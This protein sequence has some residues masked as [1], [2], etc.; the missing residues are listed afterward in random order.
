MTGIHKLLG[1]VIITSVLA[2]ASG[3]AFLSHAS[4]LSNCRMRGGARMYSQPRCLGETRLCLSFPTHKTQLN[5]LW[6]CLAEHRCSGNVCSFHEVKDTSLVVQRAALLPLQKL[7]VC[8][9]L[10]SQCLKKDHRA[11]CAY[12]GKGTNSSQRTSPRHRECK[13]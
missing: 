7:P 10:S 4:Q 13:C 1:A 11:A 8:Q 5:I 9:S 6:P 3:E 2:T 12:M